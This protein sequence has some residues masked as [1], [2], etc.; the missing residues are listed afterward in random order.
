[1]AAFTISLLA[2]KK[3]KDETSDHYISNA[4]VARSLNRFCLAIS[5]ALRFQ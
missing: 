3:G 4:F 5:A 2:E 1:M